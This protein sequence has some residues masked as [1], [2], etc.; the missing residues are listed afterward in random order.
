MWSITAILNSV[1]FCNYYT[2]TETG[3]FIQNKRVNFA[4]IERNKYTSHRPANARRADAG[5]AEIS[6][7]LI[8]IIIFVGYLLTRVRH[9]IVS[10]IS[11][12]VYVFMSVRC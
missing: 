3:T 12:L 7:R 9:P 8:T 11:E 5:K 1:V 10:A 2:N 6:R 4:A